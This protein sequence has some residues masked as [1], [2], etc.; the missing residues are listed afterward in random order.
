MAEKRSIASLRQE[1]EML[2]DRI[3]V[4]QK[5]LQGMKKQRLQLKDRLDKAKAFEIL[6]ILDQQNISFEDATEILRSQN[7]VLDPGI[8]EVSDSEIADC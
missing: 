6:G 8:K 7:P 3:I 1:L 2:D 5:K 4:Q